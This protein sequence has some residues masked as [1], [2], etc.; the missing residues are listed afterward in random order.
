MYGASLILQCALFAQ[1]PADDTNNEVAP[2]TQQPAASGNPLPA[3]SSPPAGDST[4]PPPAQSPRPISGTLPPQLPGGTAP[5]AG[6]TN[7]P[8]LLPRPGIASPPANG[9]NADPPLVTPAAATTP[10]DSPNAEKLRWGNDR[11]LPGAVAS[12]HD[13]QADTDGMVPVEPPKPRTLAQQ[14][15]EQALQPLPEEGQNALDGRRVT[16]ERFLSETELLQPGHGQTLAAYWELSNAVARYHL[17]VARH[18]RLEELSEPQSQEPL[19]LELAVA[20]AD[21]DAKQL[22]L[23]ALRAQHKLAGDLSQFVQGELPL[24]VERP[25]V[26]EYRTLYDVLFGNRAVGS[27]SVAQARQLHQTLPLAHAAL[28]AQAEAVRRAR[29]YADAA[30]RAFTEQRVS[31]GTVLSASNLLRRHEEAFLALVLDYNQSIARYAILA[32][33]PG[34]RAS[35]LFPMVQ[36]VRPPLAASGPG[37]SQNVPQQPAPTFAGQQSAQPIP[38]TASQA[39]GDIVAT[40]ATG[41]RD[42][43]QATGAETPPSSHEQPRLR[44]IVVRRGKRIP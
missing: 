38:V 31:P 24:P 44:S 12:Q 2:A 15:L 30:G 27:E 4:N 28:H 39:P 1:L 7:E 8:D 17:A 42:P 35:V 40:G 21:A 34:A 20:A 3:E 32:A 10:T 29:E 19:E 36:K 41:A 22:R 18:R 37:N 33:P 5:P 11:P 9:Q 43:R 23:K 14:L 25:L 6:A 16:L 13:S 26:A